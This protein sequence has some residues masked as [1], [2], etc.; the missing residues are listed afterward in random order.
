MWK[1]SNCGAD[2]TSNFCIKCGGNKEESAAYTT[3]KEGWWK[4]FRCGAEIDGNFC[5]KCRMARMDNDGWQ[6]ASKEPVPQQRMS[7]PPIAEPAM[8]QQPMPEQP[9]PGQPMPG[10]PIVKPATPQQPAPEHPIP[11]PPTSESP[12]PEEKT[13]KKG[14]IIAI[15]V[16]VAV[17]ALLATLI[18]LALRLITND[19]RGAG[20]EGNIVVNG[21]EREDGNLEI[22]GPFDFNLWR[23]GEVVQ[24][25]GDGAILNVPLPPDTIMREVEIEGPSLWLSQGEGE[26]W[27]RIGVLLLG[28]KRNEL[29]HYSDFEVT[30]ALD[31]HNDYGQVL[32]HSI[33]HQDNATL[34]IIQWEDEY[35]EGI[36][37]TKISE[38]QGFIVMTEVAFD[39]TGIREDFFQA[40]GFNEDFQSILR[41]YGD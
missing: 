34:L 32:N 17:I 21:E 16:I 13:S 40:Y 7:K 38:S 35:G 6:R 20:N 27:F 3:P 4:C 24:V 15:V 19:D 36:T 2:N 18:S 25:E 9:M 23:G 39:V 8:P 10:Q 33:Y 37:F 22:D 14:V 41:D 5:S 1:C 11:G 28:E 12:M 31:W 26:E 29:G 30:R